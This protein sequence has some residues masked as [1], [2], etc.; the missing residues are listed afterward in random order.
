MAQ[1]VAE[2]QELVLNE[3]ELARQEEE[4]LAAALA[5][6]KRDAEEKG[7]EAT[8]SPNPT[9]RHS[10]EAPGGVDSG[11][12]GSTPWPHD[13]QPDIVDL[14]EW[15]AARPQRRSEV[16][17]AGAAASAAAVPSAGGAAT[18]GS[19]VGGSGSFGGEKDDEALWRP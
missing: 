9:A 11:S 6:S 5:A 19:F 15:R 18:S 1:A 13:R 8:E 14:A 3:Q 4:V 10:W 2:S 12:S 16:A 7:I 17:D